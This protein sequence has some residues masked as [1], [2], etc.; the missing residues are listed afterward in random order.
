MD[1]DLTD[2]D[3]DKFLLPTLLSSFLQEPLNLDLRLRLFLI[4]SDFGVENLLSIGFNS[5]IPKI[6]YFQ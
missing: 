3:Q 1:L 5:A 4:F 2:T 6:S